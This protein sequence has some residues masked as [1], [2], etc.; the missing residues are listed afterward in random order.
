MPRMAAN[1]GAEIFIFLA[2]HVFDPDMVCYGQ[3]ID[4]GRFDGGFDQPKGFTF[5]GHE[6]ETQWIVSHLTIAD[7]HRHGQVKSQV[8]AKVQR[9]P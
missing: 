1:C 2:A 7:V 3:H 9:Y 5:V 8:V 4:T 6:T